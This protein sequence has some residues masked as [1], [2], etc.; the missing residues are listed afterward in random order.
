MAT[1]EN[2]IPKA[3]WKG[4]TS[5]NIQPRLL[6]AWQTAVV[7][8]DPSSPARAVGYSPEE[9]RTLLTVDADGT[10]Q[11]VN[12]KSVPWRLLFPTLAALSFAFCCGHI[13]YLVLRFLLCML[14]G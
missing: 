1:Q 8:Y 3:D 9:L 4:L 5:G 7:F 14:W 6:K 11:P 10:I 13:L 12:R 2:P